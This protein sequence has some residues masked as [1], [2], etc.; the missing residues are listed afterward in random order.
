MELY[1]DD[2]G[3][4]NRPVDNNKRYSIEVTD[5][6]R[7]KGY[8]D[9]TNVFSCNYMIPY[10]A[11]REYYNDIDHG[12]IK[13]WDWEGTNVNNEDPISKMFMQA[14]NATQ[15]GLH[16]TFMLTLYISANE[17]LSFRREN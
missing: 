4:T 3:I 8:I 7:M 2:S 13:L 16:T 9:D 1:S 11:K 17:W 14:S 15:F 12:I 6:G 5:N 10:T